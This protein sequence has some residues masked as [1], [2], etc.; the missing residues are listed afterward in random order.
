MKNLKLLL[1]FLMPII[2]FAANVSVSVNKTHLNTGEELIITIHAQGHNVK[3]PNITQIDGVNI[4]GNSRADNI[5]VINGKMK[6]SISQSYILYP[7]KS[8]T[9]PSFSIIVDSKTYHTKPIKITVQEPKQTKG[10]FELDVNI[11]K[12]TLYLGENAILTMKFI[13]TKN[14]DS[15]NIQKPV[16]KN[17]VLKEIKNYSIIKN[18]KKISIFKFLLIPQKSGEYNIGPFVASIGYIVN[19]TPQGF[20]GLNIATMQYKNIYSNKLNIKV[21]EIPLNSVFGNFK[22]NLKVQKT[23]LKTNEP[24]KVTIFLKGCGD[25]YSIGNFKLNIPNATVYS[26]KSIKHLEIINNKLCGNFSQTFTILSQYNYTIPQIKF[27]EFNGTLKTLST[28]PVHVNVFTTYINFHRH[29]QNRPIIKVIKKI[30]P[31]RNIIII[32]LISFVIGIIIGYLFYII[33][34]KNKEFNEIKKA[35]D[36]ELLN[37]LKKYEDNPKI[38][39]FMQKLEENIYKNASNHINKKDIIKIIKTIKRSKYE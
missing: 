37:I 35:N 11:S 23:T 27:T 14:A 10:D 21:K 6:E 12:K 33:S 15:I 3:F 24:N 31:L 39:E 26:S 7:L 5:S 9:I 1:A 34:N 30:F 38:K 36:K 17:F 18:H 29:K 19:T 22:L 16:I 32:A 13:Q 20:M 2:L 8:I 28:K 25:F 4:V